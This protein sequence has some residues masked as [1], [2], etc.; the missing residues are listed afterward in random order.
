MA[1]DRPGCFGFAA[2]YNV[3][4]KVCAQC[5]FKQPCAARAEASLKTIADQVNITGVL[6]LMHEKRVAARQVVNVTR[7]LPVAAVT[8]L[9]KLPKHA[10]KIAEILIRSRINLRKILREGSNP[11]SSGKPATI[12][13]LFDLMLEGEVSRTQYIE[14]LKTRLG[15][16]DNTASSQAS[17]GFAV[18][19]GLGIAHQVRPG[20]V[21][22]RRE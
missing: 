7:S 14:A 8:A 3:K 17:I 9:S 10:A 16:S 22:L 11:L 13:V 15:H 21:V 1:Y 20:T 2:T 18:V 5:S 12:A 6:Q 4:S 19:T